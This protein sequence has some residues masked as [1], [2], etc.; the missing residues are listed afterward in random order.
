MQEVYCINSDIYSIDDFLYQDL[1]F[2]DQTLDT[3]D[4]FYIKTEFEVYS[5][6]CGEILCSI[7]HN[8][9]KGELEI[10]TV[11]WSVFKIVAK[12]AFFVFGS[13]LSLCFE[14]TQVPPC[15]IMQ[16]FCKKIIILFNRLY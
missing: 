11:D 14:T 7:C 2:E 13:S 6:F 16:Q 12:L 15:L 10:L 1:Y 3:L 5:S 9:E 8:N 4:H